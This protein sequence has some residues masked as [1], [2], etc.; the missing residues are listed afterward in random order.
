M[1]KFKIEVTIE[2]SEVIQKLLFLA[3]YKWLN[4]QT[5]IMNTNFHYLY[6]SGKYLTCGYIGSNF[7]NNQNPEITL[8]EF[9]TEIELELNEKFQNK[10]YTITV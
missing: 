1:R 2:E 5:L 7:I 6:F 8:E 3:G 10:C 4:G 9:I